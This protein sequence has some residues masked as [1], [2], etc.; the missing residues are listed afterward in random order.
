MQAILELEIH[1]NKKSVR[2]PALMLAIKIKLLFSIWKI[3]YKIKK[4]IF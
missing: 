2:H 3:I 4:K 1:K